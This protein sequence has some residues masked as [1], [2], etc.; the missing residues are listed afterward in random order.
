MH[1]AVGIGILHF[2]A[3]PTSTT[4]GPIPPSIPKLPITMIIITIPIIITTGT[5]FFPFQQQT[6]FLDPTNVFRFAIIGTAVYYPV[7]CFYAERR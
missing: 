5:G 7:L 1:T 6:T 2:C 4:N 3:S